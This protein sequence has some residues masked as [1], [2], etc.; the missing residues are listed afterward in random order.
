MNKYLKSFLQRGIAFGG[1]GPIVAGLVLFFIDLGTESIM[2]DG[3]EILLAIVS[4][5]ILAF[6]QAGVSVFNQIE[7]WSP[8]RSL[9]CHFSLLFVTYSLTYILNSWIPFE[10]MVLLIFCLVFILVYFIIWGAVY[11]AVRAHTRKLNSRL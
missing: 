4:T 11:L 5:Y 2:L 6:V 10:P 1:L 3:G 7:H 9:L 8:A